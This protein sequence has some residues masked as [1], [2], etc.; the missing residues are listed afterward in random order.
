M[1]SYADLPVWQERDGSIHYEKLVLECSAE[2]KFNRENA[3]KYSYAFKGLDGFWTIDREF[4]TEPDGATTKFRKGK[5]YKLGLSTR[6]KSGS[7]DVWLNIERIEET[8]EPVTQLTGS[9][10]ASTQS[11]VPS[12]QV[13][14]G[15]TAFDIIGY[16]PDG[17]GLS[18]KDATIMLQGYIRNKVD[19]VAAQIAIEGTDLPPEVIGDAYAANESLGSMVTPLFRAFGETEAE[20][21]PV[22]NV[23]AAETE[24]PPED[25]PPLPW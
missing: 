14:Q 19:L 16:T 5:T 7:D 22:D 4:A 9:A 10:P 8:D 18:L 1:A 2:G 17:Y 25:N 23:V 11:D 6:P 21:E 15:P 3:N 20:P 12:D 24:G 13:A